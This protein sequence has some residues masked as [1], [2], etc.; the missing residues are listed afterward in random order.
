MNRQGRRST[1]GA[2][3]GLARAVVAAI[4][5]ATLAGCAPPGARER[6]EEP[7]LVLDAQPERV[8]VDHPRELRGAWIAT[9][10][11]IDFPSRPGLSAAAQQEELTAILDVLAGLG[12]NA[13]FFQVRP[14]GDAL[15]RSE[16]EP[17]SRFL[18]GVQGRDPGYDPLE[19]L[20]QEA[21]ARNLEVHAWFN[22]YRAKSARK[23]SANAPHVSVRRP[24][25]TRPYGALLWMDPGL[26]E[27]REHTAAVV[28]D[29]VER[30][31]I[32]GVHFDDYFYPYPSGIEF[33]DADTYAAYRKAGGTL[34]RA[35]WRRDNVHRLVETVAVGVR[36]R[37]PWVRFGISPFGIY[38]PNEPPGIRGLNQV[39]AIYSD[40]LHWAR[41]GWVDYLAPQLYWPTTQQAQAHE[42]LLLWWA[43][44][45]EANADVYIGNFL[46]QV[47]A[48]PA[49]STRE[50]ETQRA[51][52]LNHP[53]VGGNVWFSGR[54]LLEDR[55]GVRRMFADLYA[56]P[57]L[58]PPLRRRAPVDVEPP[59]VEIDDDV[60]CL[61]HPEA[62]AL[63]A[64]AVYREG[65]DGWTLHRLVPAAPEGH[66]ALPP[67][68]YAVS[69]VTRDGSESPGQVVTV[70]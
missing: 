26:S 68:R 31:D 54:P 41:Q 57:A 39:D 30:Y 55:H 25:V 8:I 64:Y 22:P 66:V 11:N 52:A 44:A 15:Y 51:L 70:P 63:R 38:K 69:V 48:S 45:V 23:Q 27:V 46:S 4:V 14:E 60:L 16:L 58:T 12:F 50:L 5:A 32:D 67:G 18:T 7:I 43:D 36:A 65:D 59:G 3:S 33:P 13:V 1:R 28:F 42:V 9:V 61:F 24:H 29:V 56:A 35:D 37:K 47:G 53:G 21:H 6:E 10:A 34:E 40:P 19:F 49:W 2:P 62:D 17:W 20:V